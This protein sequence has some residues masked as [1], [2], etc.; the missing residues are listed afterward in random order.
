MA[1]TRMIRFQAN[2][3]KAKEL[4]GGVCVVCG[5]QEALDFDHVD[6]STK[7]FRIANGWRYSEELFWAEVA[8]CQLLCRPHHI[9]KSL[10][11]KSLGG[12]GAG[13]RGSPGSGKRK[14]RELDVKYIR[15]LSALGHSQR[16][17]AREFG[18]NQTCIGKILRGENWKSL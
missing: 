15:G 5:I 16:A 8:K 4:L 18:V 17:I 1:T 9:E 10:R 14:L 7:L 6:P 12:W 2:K 11:E 13:R 3:E